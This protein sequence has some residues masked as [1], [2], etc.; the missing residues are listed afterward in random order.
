MPMVCACHMCHALPPAGFSKQVRSKVQKQS[1]PYQTA[2]TTVPP[3]CLPQGIRLNPN[4]NFFFVAHA[5]AFRPQCMSVTPHPP[6]KNSVVLH[7]TSCQ[8]PGSI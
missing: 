8:T 4:P 6:C 5:E 7:D 2:C 1:K 3:A